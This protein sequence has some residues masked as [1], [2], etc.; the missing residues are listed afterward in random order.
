MACIGTREPTSFG[1]QETQSL[2]KIL[3]EDDWSIV[4]GLALG[5]DTAAHRQALESNGHTVAVL[6][7]GLDTISPRENDALAR[8]ILDKGGALIS[9]QQFGISAIGG[10]L[11]NRNRLQCGMSAG[12]FV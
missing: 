11:I 7:I 10:N 6:G 4:S 5:I 8:Q 3:V 9:E 2:V 12:T 1:I